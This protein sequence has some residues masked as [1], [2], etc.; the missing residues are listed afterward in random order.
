MTFF[1]TSF[2]TLV[3]ATLC[4][5]GATSALPCAATGAQPDSTIVLLSEDDGRAQMGLK[6]T[7]QVP[8]L[9]HTTIEDVPGDNGVS[10]LV[11]PAVA[12]M[13]PGGRQVVRFVLER[14]DKPLLVQHL[15]RVSF[16][17][18]SARDPRDEGRNVVRV[19]AR[20]NIPLVISPKG[21][22]QDHEPWKRLVFTLE[23]NQVRVENPSPYVIRVHQDVNL[24]PAGVRTQLFPRT[25]LLPGDNFVMPLPEGVAAGS[26]QVIRLYPASPWGFGLAPFEVRLSETSA[27][28][29]G[30]GPPR[31]P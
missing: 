7:E 18:I 21:L 31:T 3:S 22:K 25:Y 9:L 4:V 12:R 1:M 30:D 28:T 20:Q 23:G 5:L 6:N 26:V 2:R 19:G 16:D 10:V 17:G 8:L 11:L 24:F 29:S 13:E 14:S 27:S 15:K